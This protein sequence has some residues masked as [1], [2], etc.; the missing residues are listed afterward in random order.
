MI[1][2][3]VREKETIESMLKRFKQVYESSNLQKEL[4]KREY[5]ISPSEKRH[6]DDID[7][8]KKIKKLNIKMKKNEK[9]ELNKKIIFPL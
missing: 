1:G 9:K 5:Y 4:K 3:K 6:R 8:K 2:I 7:R